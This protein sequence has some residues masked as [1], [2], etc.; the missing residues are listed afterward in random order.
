MEFNSIKHLGTKFL[1][2]NLCLLR[3]STLKA[4]CPELEDH[5]CKNYKH[6]A[7]P[8]K[9]LLFQLDPSK[10]MGPHGIHLRILKVL[11]SRSLS[12]IF[13]QSWILERS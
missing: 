8:V 5:D 13:E 3:S 2:Q 12:M 10:S 7:G 6:T 1:V 11:A 9:D 4:P